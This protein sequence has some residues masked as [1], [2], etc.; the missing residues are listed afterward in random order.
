MKNT[1]RALI[2]VA[3]CTL[4]ASCVSNRPSVVQ[5]ENVSTQN[6]VITVGIDKERAEKVTVNAG[7]R[8]IL[9]VTN[10]WVEVRGKAAD[11]K[12]TYPK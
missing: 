5:L 12:I 1:T 4:S 11:W 9:P 6:L 10:A 8:V 2:G 7:H 3:L